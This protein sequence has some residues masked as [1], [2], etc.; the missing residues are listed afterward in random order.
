MGEP[1]AGRSACGSTKPSGPTV[2]ER[3]DPRVV[4]P[5]SS[6]GVGPESELVRGRTGS[7]SSRSGTGSGP[8]VGLVNGA[9]GQ[10]DG[11]HSTSMIVSSVDP[12]DP[13]LVFVGRVPEVPKSPQ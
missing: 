13:A 3:R 5:E 6:G 1:P 2:A 7:K 9:S 4:G 12:V 10:T 8:E 11:F